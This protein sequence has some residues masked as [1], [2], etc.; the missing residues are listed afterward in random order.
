VPS[1]SIFVECCKKCPIA[2]APQ[3]LSCGHIYKLRSYFIFCI[4]LIMKK[5]FLATTALFA[6]A[7]TEPAPAADL[8]VRYTKAPLLEPV[9]VFNWTGFYVGGHIGLVTGAMRTGGV[10]DIE[11]CFCLDPR[12]DLTQTLAGVHAGY[13][14][15]FNRFVLGVEADANHRFGEGVF[16]ATQLRT[17]S[18]GDASIRGRF[19]VLMTPQALLYATGGVAFGNFKT[20]K[21]IASSE[22]T[23][24]LL[25]G[26]RVG[27]TLGGGVE[28]ALDNAWSARIE[29]RH[30][31]WGSKN[32]IW[33]Y[34]DINADD[35]S[36]NVGS[37]LIDNRVAV[38]LSY[39]IGG[40]GGPLQ[41]RAQMSASAA[42][43]HSWTGF[44]LGG[45]VGSSAGKMNVVTVLPTTDGDDSVYGGFNQIL[46]GVHGGYNYQ[47]NNFVVG[48]EGDINHK[49][50]SGTLLSRVQRPTS[51]WDGSIRARVGV[52]VTPQALVYGTAGFAFGHF[53]TPWHEAPD[54]REL[55]GGL[56][57]EPLEL[58]GGMRTGWTAGGG[59]EYALDS[60][61]SAR[62][63]YRYTNWGSKGVLWSSAEDVDLT[64]SSSKL[65]ETRVVTGLTYKV[66]PAA[67][68]AARDAVKANW[69]GFYA[70]GQVGSSAS[71]LTFG[72]I[73]NNHDDSEFADFTQALVGGYGGYNFV[74][75]GNIVLGVEGDINKKL[76]S[77][78]KI[79]DVLRP[80]S[81]WDGSVRARFGYAATA[82]SLFYVTG[83]WAF[84]D[85]STP[86]S[87]AQER[88]NGGASGLSEPAEEHIGGNRSGWT[89]GAGMEYALDKNWST[90]I[91]YRYTD[92]GTKIQP[93][94][95]DDVNDIQP[96]KLTDN[97]IAVGLGYRFSGDGGV[98][99]A[100]Y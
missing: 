19:G 17:L 71:H 18:D 38:G 84:G 83:G 89:V 77:G 1:T 14:Y 68:F 100:K 72:G 3:P 7:A 92:W 56:N 95:P 25:G 59:I 96:S 44:Y 85:F 88:F 90:R 75:R 16:R 53:T 98:V 5:L 15:Q 2:R 40:V 54:E 55:T 57:P 37:R 42:A 60:N 82:R 87:G 48:A 79:D 29:Y 47:L 35:A 94:F 80:T 64:Q 23:S 22:L 27:W 67:N 49:S 66:G 86:Q 36:A 70:G 65:T 50:G 33:N 73:N 8:P 58:L 78:F 74:V 43:V 30:T 34:E 93:G 4:G 62:I 99:A 76:G 45:H 52:L 51:D 6:L 26:S 21:A 9:S 12:G 10:V 46:A 24:D 91:D 41:A 11:D 13:N 31:D 32:V 20:D 28:Y 61:W 81:S 63:D 39:H 97:R 69:G